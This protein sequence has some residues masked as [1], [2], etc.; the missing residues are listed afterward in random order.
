M[1]PL[2]IRFAKEMGMGE[3]TYSY[4]ARSQLLLK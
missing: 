4:I 2:L 3:R 1:Y